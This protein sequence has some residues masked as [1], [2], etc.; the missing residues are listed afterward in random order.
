[1]RAQRELAKL[2]WYST[3]ELVLLA[4][5]LRK[6]SQVTPSF[7]DAHFPLSYRYDKKTIT[8]KFSRWLCVIFWHECTLFYFIYKYDSNGS[9]ALCFSRAA[10]SLFLSPYIV[11]LMYL[12][13]IIVLF[14]LLVI[15][16]SRNYRNILWDISCWNAEK[17][18]SVLWKI[19]APQRV[20]TGL[21]SRNWD[22]LAPR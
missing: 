22:Y 10:M 11:Y 17:F 19:T 15:Y 13:C 8:N 5:S 4:E 16:K 20:D 6:F 3:R 7:G 21:I 14:N 18:C 9:T 12:H 1:M 2:S